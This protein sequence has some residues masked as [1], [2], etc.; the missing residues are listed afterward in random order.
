MKVSLAVLVTGILLVACHGAGH[1][2]E[3]APD[4]VRA[5]TVSADARARSGIPALQVKPDRGRH[6]LTAFLDREAWQRFARAAAI[7]TEIGNIDFRSQALIA[8][9]SDDELRYVGWLAESDGGVLVVEPSAGESVVIDPPNRITV[10]LVVVRRDRLRQVRLAWMAPDSRGAAALTLR[11]GGFADTLVLPLPGWPAPAP[12][13]WTKLDSM[14]AM[15]LLPPDAKVEAGVGAAR[16]ELAARGGSLG[17]SRI[18]E[19][20]YDLTLLPEMAEDVASQRCRVI[21]D[22]WR[23]TTPDST[24]TECA[25][26]KPGQ[27][28]TTKMSTLVRDRIRKRAFQCAA[29]FVG[30]VA[31]SRPRIEALRTICESLDS[32]G[33]EHTQAS[34]LPSSLTLVDVRDGFTAGSR[35]A[36]QW[37][38][39]QVRWNNEDRK[40]TPQEAIRRGRS[41]G[42]ENEITRAITHPVA[43]EYLAEDSV[44]V[45]TDR[46]QF[47][48]QL[49][50]AS[51]SG[52]VWSISAVACQ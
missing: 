33:D 30:D 49:D 26:E 52:S 32:E 37:F 27:P 6:T 9:L 3:P 34:M 28:P 15:V 1:P 17:I 40:I 48:F 12:S 42:I 2:R 23:G 51:R 46:C 50:M 29:T 43:V 10:V 44:R 38:R 41:T 18:H 7:D 45:R 4:G 25:S 36:P 21:V 8:V 13:V 31:S 14:A 47:E 19:D 35:L 22:P 5:Y 11:G 16:I 24:L 39:E 20:E